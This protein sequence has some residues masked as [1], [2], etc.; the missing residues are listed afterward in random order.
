MEY[1][2]TLGP[3]NTVD[4]G[5]QLRS[6]SEADEDSVKQLLAVNPA[7]KRRYEEDSEDSFDADRRRPNKR[8]RLA[9]EPSPAPRKWKTTNMIKNVRFPPPKKIPEIDLRKV[10]IRRRVPV[11][12]YEKLKP[13]AFERF[14]AT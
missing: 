11:L 12:R 14:A 4:P 3:S 5:E 13:Q 1:S 7:P 10:K 6:D 2:R 8:A 9:N